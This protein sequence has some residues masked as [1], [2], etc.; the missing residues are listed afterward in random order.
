[1]DMPIMTYFITDNFGTDGQAQR[2][3]PLLLLR[4]ETR[5][6]SAIENEHQT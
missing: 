6:G 2:V 3:L 1:M 4:S 5:L